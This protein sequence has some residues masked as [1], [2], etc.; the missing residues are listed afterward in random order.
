MESVNIRKKMLETWLH[1]DCALS[2]LVLQPMVGDASFRRYFRVRTPKGS[3][4]AMDAPPPQ[5]NCRPYV[6]IA[7]ALRERGLL[8]PEVIQA[9]LE[10][11]FLLLTDLGDRTYLSALNKKNV[12]E[13]Y[14]RA[15]DALEVMQGCHPIFNYSLPPFTRELM[16]QEWAWHKEWFLEKWLGLTLLAEEELDECYALLVETA[17]A[18]PQVFMHRDYHAGN[19]M[20]LPEKVGI[21]DFQDAFIGPITYDPAS[22]LRDCYID[23]PPEWV[24]KWALTYFKQL[25]Q[26]G[27]LPQINKEDFLY[28]FDLMSVQRHLKALLTFA[29]KQVRDQ[30][31]QY[32]NYVPRTLMYLQQVSSKYSELT[33]LHRYVTE[34]VMPAVERV[35][36]CV[37]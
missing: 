10:H 3:F 28:W 21:L 24:T 33:T 1:T 35:S 25:H 9:D 32:L 16:W 6:A 19:L 34:M 29:R 31:S 26:L 18:Q 20:V 12:D 7:S 36:T 30:Q 4:V 37:P 14:H 27:I 23:W 5:E 22:L 2:S 8:A 13:L 11:G 15:L 17:A